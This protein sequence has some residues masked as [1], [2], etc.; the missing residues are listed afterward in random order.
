MMKCNPRV[1]KSMSCPRIGNEKSARRFS[2]R[3]FFMDVSGMSVPKC[4]FFQDLEGLTQV[5]GRMSAGIS[6]PKLPL[7]ADFF[8]PERSWEKRRP[9][10]GAKKVWLRETDFYP[11]WVLGGSVLALWGCQTPAQ[12]W[13]KNCAPMGPEILSSIGAGF[14]IKGVDCPKPLLL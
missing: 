2:D 3:S 7:W 8:V 9:F 10:S 5:F 11:V 12:H 1:P 4:F 6:A 14:A 13:D